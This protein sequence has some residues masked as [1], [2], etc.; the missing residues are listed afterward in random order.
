MPIIWLSFA[1]PYIRNAKVAVE[2]QESGIVCLVDNS[3]AI[4][5]QADLLCRVGMVEV[6]APGHLIRLL[7]A[8]QSAVLK[9]VPKGA[10][11]P[12]KFFRH[13]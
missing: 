1:L 12:N 2:L 13:Y 9:S 10:G 5:A 3:A 11:M 6:N 7:A 8:I 4:Q